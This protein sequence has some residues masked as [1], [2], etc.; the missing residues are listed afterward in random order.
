MSGIA[1][2]VDLE[3]KPEP[4]EIERMVEVLLHRGPDDQGIWGGEQAAFAC[5][6]LKTTPESLNEKLPFSDLDAQLVITAD[7]RLDNRSELL[8]L[9]SLDARESAHISDSTIILESYKKWGISCCEHLLGDFAVAIWD[10]REQKFFAFKDHFGVRPFYYYHSDKYFAFSSEIKA[11]LALPEIPCRVNEERIADFIAIQDDT[12]STFF[13]NIHILPPAHFLTFGHAGL[14][15]RK[16]W[17]LVPGPILKLANN[18]EYTA[19]FKEVFCKSVGSRLRGV[20]PIGS[21]LS[22][23]LDSSSVTAT[24]R[25]M[26]LRDGR[27]KLHTFSF[28]FE[29]IKEC[30]ERK[31]IDPIIQQ[32]GV[33]SHYVQADVLPK[34]EEYDEIQTAFEGADSAF[35]TYPPWRVMRTARDNG[36]K[37][38]LSGTDGDTTVSHGTGRLIELARSMQWLKLYR[39]SKGYGGHF[40]ISTS[41]LFF[42]Y[43]R[44]YSFLSVFHENTVKIK[45]IIRRIVWQ[46]A[47]KNNNGTRFSFLAENFYKEINAD[48]RANSLKKSFNKRKF[49]EQLWHYKRIT[50]PSLPR[51]LG[52][53]NR[54]SSFF[55]IEERYPFMDKRLVE[56]CLS[57]PATQKLDRGFN[58]IIM[59]RAMEASLPSSVCW[60]GG[61]ADLGP[62]TNA[63][64]SHLLNIYALQEDGKNQMAYTYLHKERVENTFQSYITNSLD[65]AGNEQLCRVVALM[66]WLQEMEHWFKLGESNITIKGGEINGKRNQEGKV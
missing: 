24:A 6:L 33:I 12:C 56:F 47:Q 1:G 15:K 9:L 16:Y 18:D 35:N 49:N 20:D 59:R 50:S 51:I 39:E 61:K 10:I 64:V 14:E 60:R 53:T 23:G 54:C 8:Q 40:K 43:L 45:K 19:A 55:S 46:L 32:G 2:V 44:N 3:K 63:L 28:Y 22:G 31:Y 34:K 27:E 4:A 13:K 48:K 65:F 17:E 30:D 11:L 66:T 26:L 36:V 7:A 42:Y 57:L 21:Y 37:I 5:L 25:D 29:N 38:L 62:H 52:I 58:R 41:N